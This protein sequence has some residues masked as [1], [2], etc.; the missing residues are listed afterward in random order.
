MNETYEGIPS[1][2]YLSMSVIERLNAMYVYTVS[3]LWKKIRLPYG[4]LNYYSSTSSRLSL[5]RA[6]PLV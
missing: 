4:S 5:V 1:L 3:Y 6:R 2:Y